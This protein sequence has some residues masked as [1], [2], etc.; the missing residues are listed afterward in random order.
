[1]GKILTQ[2]NVHIE[3]DDTHLFLY[4]Q[5]THTLNQHIAVQGSQVYRGNAPGDPDIFKHPISADITG[6]WQII[7][8]SQ[9]P[10]TLDENNPESAEFLWP[11]TAEWHDSRG[12]QTAT[13]ACM[14]V[15]DQPIGFIGFAFTHCTVLTDGQL[16]FIQALTNQATL[17]IY[18]TR[19]ADQS[20]RVALT[21]E[22]NRLAREIHDTL[23]QAFTGVSLQLEAVRGITA[24]NDGVEP[25]F[26]DFQKAQAYIRR[27]RDL[28]RK[29]LSEARRSVRALR[30]EALETET[31]PNALRKTLTQTTRDTGLQTHFYLEGDPLPLPDDLQ[32]NLLR[33][34][35]EAVTNTLRH[36]QA[37]QLDLTLGFTPEHIQLR[38]V[39]NGSGFDTASLDTVAGFGLVGMRERAARFYGTLKLRSNSDIGTT[40]DIVIPFST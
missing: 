5:E 1:L 36:A 28:A 37:T 32:L 10:F 25:T 34:S 21:D 33:I 24:L 19:L 39:D 22:R 40:I 7:T 23:A 18:L 31:L 15:G 38:I 2:I 9:K 20:Q 8:R 16:E 29:G 14:R 26:A 12:H 13:C 30:A 17:S 3:A 6:A 11:G 27:A 35:Q 4:D